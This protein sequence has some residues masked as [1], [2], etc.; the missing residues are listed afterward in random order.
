ML[1]F[2]DLGTDLIKPTLYVPPGAMSEQERACYVEFTQ[3]VLS[4]ESG[5]FLPLLREV[6]KMI[7]PKGGTPTKFTF[8]IE[9]EYDVM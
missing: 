2:S 1:Q 8:K 3:S 4:W 9:V 6:G 7:D 5:T